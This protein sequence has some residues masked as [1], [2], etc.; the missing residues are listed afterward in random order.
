[1]NQSDLFDLI[2]EKSN[3]IAQL[4]GELSITQQDIEKLKVDVNDAAITAHSLKYDSNNMIHS[5]NSLS[6]RIDALEK[7]VDVLCQ[8]FSFLFTQFD[9]QQE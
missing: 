8:H 9:E 1:M 4:E 3:Q 2:V 7:K 6:D 5:Q